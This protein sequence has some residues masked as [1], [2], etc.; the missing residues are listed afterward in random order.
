MS[1]SALSSANPSKGQ[2]EFR[3][4][5]KYQAMYKGAHCVQKR[6]VESYGNL[7][8]EG[9]SAKKNIAGPKW[10][11]RFRVPVSRRPRLGL[12]LCNGSRRRRNNH[13]NVLSALNSPFNGSDGPSELSP[14]AVRKHGKVFLPPPSVVLHVPFPRRVKVRLVKLGHLHMRRGAVGPGH[15]RLLKL[16]LGAVKVQVVVTPKVVVPVD[17]GLP[18]QPPF[19][20]VFGLV[21]G[22]GD[23][24]ATDV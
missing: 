9:K 15:G 12:A 6:M 14:P 3:S 20:L 11:G 5:S 17:H 22:P 13:G 16:C 18:S 23:A 4:Q 2:I 8:T 19:P 10:V 21:E 7:E 24:N 1:L